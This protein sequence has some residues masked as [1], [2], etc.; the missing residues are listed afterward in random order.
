MPIQYAVPDGRIVDRDSPEAVADRLHNL[1][2]SFHG[3]LWFL[4]HEG[5]VTEA[6]IEAI[7]NE[8]EAFDPS[9][10]HSVWRKQVGQE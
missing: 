8:P 4:A 5:R 2:R 1:E 10:P 7:F 3:F 6:D 9:N